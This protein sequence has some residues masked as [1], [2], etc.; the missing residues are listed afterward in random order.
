MGKEALRGIKEDEMIKCTAWARYCKI[1]EGKIGFVV[2]AAPLKGNYI[3][4]TDKRMKM[5]VQ[6]LSKFRYKSAEHIIRSEP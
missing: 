6:I 4:Y 5:D 2:S 1:P 3:C